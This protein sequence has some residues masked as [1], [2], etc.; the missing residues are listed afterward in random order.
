M[1]AGTA[2][3]IEFA[4]GL[5]TRELAAYYLQ[6]SL[7]E[8]DELKATGALIAVGDS[9]R[10]KFTKEELDRYRLGLPERSSK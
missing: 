5:F 9:K 4:P 10:I 6:V 7:R 1:S 3:R 8:L 2:V